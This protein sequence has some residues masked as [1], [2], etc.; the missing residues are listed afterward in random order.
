MQGEFC[1]V[2]PVLYQL[3][4]LPVPFRINFKILLLTF[5]AIH[6]LSPSYI[7]DLVKIKRFNSRFNLKSN[8]GTLLSYP[9]FKT[10][11]NPGD[12]AFV[13][14]ASK[15]WNRLPREIRMAKSV[16]TFKNLLKIYLLSKAFHS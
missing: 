9:H 14:S 12:R 15:L 13:A 11:E 5:K 6:G 1:Q 2:T 16:D 3:H 10:W 7:S 8:N 4:W